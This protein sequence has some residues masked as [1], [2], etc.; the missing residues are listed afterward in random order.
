VATIDLIRLPIKDQAYWEVLKQRIWDILDFDS[1]DYS[2]HFIRRRVESRMRFLELT[3]YRDYAEL[4][5]TSRKEAEALFFNL[6]VHVTHFFRDR[7]MYDSFSHKMIP[8]LLDYKMTLVKKPILRIW[9]AGCSTGEEPISVLICV[10]E[11]LGDKVKDFFISI[12]ATDRDDAIIKAA[13]EAI[14]E[15]SQFQETEEY[16]LERYFEAYDDQH[17]KFKKEYMRYITYEV[18]DIT[19]KVQNNMDI[20]LCRNTVIYFHSDTKVKLYERFY[21]FL[22]PGGFLIMG[23]TEVLVG[24]ARQKFEVFDQKERIFRKPRH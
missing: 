24:P 14:Y 15:T 16:I 12:L 9:S 20:I 18:S 3:S 19:K 6:T 17:F 8:A 13:K 10:L 22:N 2:D 21:D 7:T 4:L 11:A 23:K 5:I 1:A